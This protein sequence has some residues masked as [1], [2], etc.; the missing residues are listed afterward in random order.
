MKIIVGA[1]SHLSSGSTS[2][3]FSKVLDSQLKPLLTLTFRHPEFRFV[4]RLGVGFIQWLETNYPEI[5]MLIG[6]LCRKG[7][8]EML[9]SSYYDSLLSLEPV[10]ERSSQLEKTNTFLRK[11]F[12]KRPR[13][14]WCVGQVFNTSFIQTMEPSSLDY[15]LLSGYNQQMNQVL[16]NKPFIMDELGKQTVIF[17]FDDKVSRDIADLAKPNASAEKF[18]SSVMKTVLSSSMAVNTF[19]FNLDQMCLCSN[20][21]AVFT[22]LVSSVSDKTYL[23]SE[24]LREH[25]V[26]SVFY[27]PSAMY[28][29]D[30]SI[31]KS[32]T[33][34]EHILT[35]RNLQRNFSLL[36]AYRDLA[37]GLKKN[38]DEKKNVDYLLLKSAPGIM[39]LS[40]MEHIPGI[41]LNTQK[42]LIET[43]LALNKA[44]ILP[45]QIDNEYIS[46]HKSYLCYI[47]PRG[48]V[49]SRL[50][51]ASPLMDL[52]MS[53]G[54]GIL[55]DSVRNGKTTDLSTR[56][57]DLSPLDKRQQDYFAVSPNV[58]VNK[59]TIRISKHFKTRQTSVTVDYEIENMGTETADFVF[60]SLINMTFEGP[61][62]LPESNVSGQISVNYGFDRMIFVMSLSDSFETVLRNVEQDVMTVL[63]EQSLY[64][65]TQIKL[66]KKIFIPASETFRFTV[67]L[68]SEKKR[69]TG[70]SI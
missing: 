39:N 3:E 11:K 23:P 48:A 53:P 31:G 5:N 52:A 42:N 22:E 2:A 24:Y 46:R 30:F 26:S 54:H 63:G 9:S 8:L 40:P 16:A 60:E 37:K 20:S 41:R 19:M 58:E 47:S 34:N 45:S 66:Q 21:N 17:P 59:T 33:V 10:H 7:Q 1:Y 14:L 13:G 62:E 44:D 29:R 32:A 18:I 56:K 70:D 27:L 15:I 6:D 4:L 69:S 57:W 36:N 61:V 55:A 51:L 67:V 68:K 49:I 38:T 43:E 25:E 28:G 50:T 65:Y 64:Q 35:D 12:S